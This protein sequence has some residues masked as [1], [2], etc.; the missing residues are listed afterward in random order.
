MVGLMGGAA[1]ELN[2]RSN[3]AETVTGLRVGDASTIN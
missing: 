1:A 3:H 2:P